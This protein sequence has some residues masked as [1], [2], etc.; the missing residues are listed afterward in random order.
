MSFS[1]ILSLI[2]SFLNNYKKEQTMNINRLQQLILIIS[3]LSINIICAANGTASI[4]YD[5]ESPGNNNYYRGWGVVQNKIKRVKNDIGGH[6]LQFTGKGWNTAIFSFDPPFV[7]KPTTIL[8]F[9][10]KTS[11]AGGWK[12]NLSNAS[13]GAEYA[14]HYS[15]KEPNKWTN[16]QVALKEAGYKRGGKPGMKIDGLV[17]DKLRS[18]QIVYIGKNIFLDDIELVDL[19]NAAFKQLGTSHPE[20]EKYLKNH[21]KI[22]YPQLAR[23]GVFPFGVIITQRGEWQNAKIFDQKLLDRY[24]YDLLTIKRNGFN[25]LADFCTRFKTETHLKLMEYYNLYLLSTLTC[26]KNIYSLPENHYVIKTVKKFSHHPNL[27]GWYGQDEP[28]DFNAYLKNKLRVETLS[29]G[30]APYT[31]AMHMTSA[32]PLAPCMEVVVVDPYSLIKKFNPAESSSILQKHRVHIDNT[33]GISQGKRVWAIAQAFSRRD[34]NRRLQRLP[35]PVEIRFDVLNYLASGANGFMFF[36]ANDTV[37]Y[38]DKK[39]RG[40]EF[41][42]TLFDAWGNGNATSRELEKLAGRLIPIMPSFLDIEPSTRLKIASTNKKI[43]VRQWENELGSLVFCVNSD[44]AKK[45]VTKIK[46]SPLKRK[47]VYNL[48]TLKPLKGASVSLNIKPGDGQLFLITSKKKFTKAAQEINFRKLVARWES[49]DIKLKILKRAGFDI[50]KIRQELAN[51]KPD[52][53]GPP[54]IIS[55]NTLNKLAEEIDDLRNSNSM[56]CNIDDGLKRIK[57][58]FGRINAALV[59]PGIIERVDKNPKWYS[60]FDT[61]QKS[62]KLYFS[63]RLD[64]SNGK[65][66]IPQEKI[67]GLED[68]LTELEKQITTKLLKNKLKP[69]W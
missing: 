3:I 10:V 4:K 64:C 54:K 7:V 15:V 30:G 42:Q 14:I 58:T 12:I 35:R 18:V 25:A 26:G 66:D 28:T 24:E 21:K 48:D 11:R 63:M 62:G 52:K 45:T 68:S 17:G 40:Q 38:L 34:N 31:S 56:Y 47:M 20:I 43:I 61:I 8:R 9:K 2:L 65:F 57:Q 50:S 60:I 13:E 69:I 16:I 36:I 44:L 55:A 27:L 29:D 1:K 46:F 37:P 19:S 67:S 33:R 6:A 5:F 23:N 59:V 49:M 39:Y 32:I 51:I 41:D 22:T 53:T